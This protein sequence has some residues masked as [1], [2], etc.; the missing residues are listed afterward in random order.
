MSDLPLKPLKWEW[1]EYFT[2]NSNVIVKTKS[3]THEYLIRVEAGGIFYVDYRKFDT[4]E[5]DR[6]DEPPEFDSCEAAQEWVE[7]THYPS[8]M[9]KWVKSVNEV[10]VELQNKVDEMGAAAERGLDA[11]NKLYKA[12]GGEDGTKTT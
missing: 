2:E 11:L 3:P 4:D 6:K 1:G 7:N 8:K 10:N 9:S 5:S 12:I